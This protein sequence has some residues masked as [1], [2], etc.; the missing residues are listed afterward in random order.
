M[1][2]KKEMM[3]FQGVSNNAGVEIVGNLVKEK[4]SL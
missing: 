2:T 1:D 3:L 4:K